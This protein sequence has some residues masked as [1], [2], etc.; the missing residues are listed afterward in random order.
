MSTYSTYNLP[1]QSAGAAHPA[2][3]SGDRRSLTDDPAK[4]AARSPLDYRRSVGNPAA[5]CRR[6]RF[7]SM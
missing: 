1:S 4:V 7:C 5:P 3:T 6:P 2:L